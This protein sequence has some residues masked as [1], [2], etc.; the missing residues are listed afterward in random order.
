MN[1]RKPFKHINSG[2]TV[3]P[4]DDGTYKVLRTDEQYPEKVFPTLNQAIQYCDAAY[5]SYQ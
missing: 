2:A 5:C 3:V 1:Q 4:Q